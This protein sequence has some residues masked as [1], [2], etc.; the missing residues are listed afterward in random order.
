MR[1]GAR[2]WSPSH[3]AD[4]ENAPGARR[5]AKDTVVFV[6]GQAGNMWRTPCTGLS[7]NRCSA[8]VPEICSRPPPPRLG[9][10]FGSTVRSYA[11]VKLRRTARASERVVRAARG[12]HAMQNPFP[13]AKSVAVLRKRAV[14]HAVSRRFEPASTTPAGKIAAV[15][16]M[17][18]AKLLVGAGCFGAYVMASANMVVPS[19]VSTMGNGA[20]FSNMCCH[21]IRSLP[22]AYT[23]CSLPGRVNSSRRAYVMRA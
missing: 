3:A 23:P 2:T 1:T 7:I 15:C 9:Q 10:P 17:K 19:S 21:I 11:R 16:V 4:T 14:A 5:F 6:I 22:F 18:K 20:K 12:G 8:C 13:G